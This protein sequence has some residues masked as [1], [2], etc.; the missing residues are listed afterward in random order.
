MPERKEED[1]KKVN[2]QDGSE[3]I[4]PADEKD[5]AGI[6]RARRS[7]DIP[8]TE[9]TKEWEAREDEGPTP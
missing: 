4:R 6:E 1:R 9:V 8:P 5:F 7:R 3:K 2:T